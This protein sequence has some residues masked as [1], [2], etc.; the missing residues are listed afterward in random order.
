[1]D[2]AIVVEHRK[3]SFPFVHVAFEHNSQSE[4]VKKVKK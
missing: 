3:I 2:D 4:K 1:V